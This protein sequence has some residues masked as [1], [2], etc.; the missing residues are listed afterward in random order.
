MGEIIDLA[1]KKGADAIHP[2]YGFLSENPEFAR[3]C[4]EAGLE[5]IG[6]SVYTLENLGDKIKSKILAHS[7]GV[8][9]IPGIDKPMTSV[10]EAAGFAETHGYPVILKAAAG[11]GGRGM[12]VVYSEK[13]LE[14][15][16]YNARNESKKAFGID[17][18]F[19]E[20]YLERPKHIEVQILADKYGNIVHLYEG[21]VPC[22]DGTRRSWN[23]PL[24]LPP[25]RAAGPAVPGR[26]ETL[27]GRQLCQCL[28]GRIPGG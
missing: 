22:R 5:F 14:R 11:G 9:T 1:L 19:I 8:P 4:A 3:K 2:G 26:P 17:D 10:E 28:Y 15:E 23:L 6:P 27:Q 12:R 25:G 21:T 13:D 24:L 16:Y 7:V 18:I 20:K